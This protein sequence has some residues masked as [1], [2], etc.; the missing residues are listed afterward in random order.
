MSTQKSTPINRLPKKQQNTNDN[1][2]VQDILNEINNGGNEDNNAFNKNTM[3]NNSLKYALDESQMVIPE[4]Q[5]INNNVQQQQPSPLPSQPQQL[6]IDD[7]EEDTKNYSND[8]NDHDHELVNEIID[9]VKSNSILDRV[10]DIMKRP[11]IVFFI[12]LIITLKPINDIILKYIP[13]FTSINGN[14]SHIINFVKAVLS[15]ILFLVA[16]TLSL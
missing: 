2:L 1:A 7:D 4:K 16:D 8:N 14:N 11:L 3:N 6:A 12:V 13:S 9:E 5:I 15:A 10:K